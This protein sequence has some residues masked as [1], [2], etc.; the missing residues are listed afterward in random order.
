MKPKLLL[1][2]ASLV[3]L[4]HTIGHTMGALTWDQAPN[5]ALANVIRGMKSEHFD[6]F[7]RQVSLGMFFQGYGY[8]MICVLLLI[9]ATLWISARNPI[10]TMTQQLLPY[11]I[12]FLALFA[13]IE[14]IY[15][16]PMPAAMSSVAAVLTFLGW[17]GSKKA[18]KSI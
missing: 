6:F 16:F 8:S 12:T 14:W 4:L 10:D 13:V 9:V 2:L 1:R 17:W 11:L 7:G 18:I 5:T 15:F 3:M